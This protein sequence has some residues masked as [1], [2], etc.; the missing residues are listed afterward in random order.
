TTKFC[1]F[2]PLAR[3]RVNTM[4]I[5]CVDEKDIFLSHF[6]V[7][8]L[9]KSKTGWTSFRISSSKF[10]P[11]PH[12]PPAPRVPLLPIRLFLFSVFAFWTDGHRA[13][14]GCHHRRP[15][16]DQR[17]PRELSDRWPPSRSLSDARTES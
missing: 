16:R 8:T 4:T 3:I 2:S 13:R 12:S 17:K 6:T 7:P 1:R 10:V 15:D 9:K 14:G 5:S 11:S